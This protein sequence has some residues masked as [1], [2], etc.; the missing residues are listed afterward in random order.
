[1]E[2]YIS[3]ILV[4]TAH[5]D[6]AELSAG[7]TIAKMTQSGFSV[8]LVDLTAGEAGTRGTPEIRI[9]ESMAA[10]EILKAKHRFNLGMPDSKL[11]ITEENILQVIKMI[12]LLRPK[13]VIMNPEFERHPDHEAAH[14]LVRKAMFK[15]GLRKIETEFNG[16]N[17]EPYRIRKMYSFMQS[18]EFKQ[19]PSFYVD[20]SD[21]FDIKMESIKAYKSQ[22]YVEGAS[23]SDEPMTRLSRPEFLQ[24]L[25]AR[26]FYFGSMLGVKYAEP[27]VSVEP[28]I[29][30]DI[31]SIVN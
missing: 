14:R 16:V 26:A 24:E 17:L 27:F 18:Y 1:M 5:P 20:I 29:I 31:S 10:K 7:G 22:V 19:K 15:S 13:A 21:T 30:K 12:R 28:L 2:E 25:E 23:T 3:D 4:I 9:A 6:D 11:S 8:S